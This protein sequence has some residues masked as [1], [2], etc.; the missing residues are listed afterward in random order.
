MSTLPAPLTESIDA[1]EFR[2]R[3]AGLIDPRG[4]NETVFADEIRERAIAF[5]VG[6]CEVFNAKS[7]DRKTIW[8]RVGSALETAHAKT[9]GVDVEFFVSRALEHVLA[10]P[11]RVAASAALGE[12][13]AWLHERTEAERQAWLTYLSQKRYA[14]LI[15]ARAVREQNK[16][17]RL[18]RQEELFDE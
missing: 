10:E 1:N 3:L 18:D 12:T 16:Q 5:V 9:V 6:L 2:Q 7:L 17:D 4:A 13:I 14:V 8:E 15:H 11:G